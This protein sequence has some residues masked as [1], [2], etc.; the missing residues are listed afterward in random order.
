MDNDELL[1]VDSRRLSRSN[2]INRKDFSEWKRSMAFD[3]HLGRGGNNH[4]QEKRWNQKWIHFGWVFLLD[5]SF[6][7]L[8]GLVY[9]SVRRWI[10]G[11]IISNEL[12]SEEKWRSCF[13]ISLSHLRM[14]IRRSWIMFSS[15]DTS[16]SCL[17]QFG[18]S[19]SPSAVRTCRVDCDAS[20][21][22]PLAILSTKSFKLDEISWFLFLLVQDRVDFSFDEQQR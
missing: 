4:Q 7:P 1:L 20:S 21:V 2:Q 14:E 12:T 22:F 3:S 9:I 19:K 5:K 18:I 17:S 16:L 13:D 11:K 8:K 10:L 6:Y 15:C